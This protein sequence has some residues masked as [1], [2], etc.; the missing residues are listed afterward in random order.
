MGTISS[1][2]G[3]SQGPISPKSIS[4]IGLQKLFC[5]GTISFCAKTTIPPVLEYTRGFT[6]PK[7]S[8]LK[9]QLEAYK[10]I[11]KKANG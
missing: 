10:L 7:L 9:Q 6:C 4:L 3:V 2:G 1:C 5:L 11:L 8:N